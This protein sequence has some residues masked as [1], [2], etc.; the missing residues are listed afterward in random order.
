MLAREKRYTLIKKKSFVS[1]V[2]IDF[3]NPITVDDEYTCKKKIAKCDQ[4]AKLRGNVAT[5]SKSLFKLFFNFRN[6]CRLTKFQEIVFDL[7]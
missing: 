1:I 2:L 6:L 4:F 7:S 3:I 5:L